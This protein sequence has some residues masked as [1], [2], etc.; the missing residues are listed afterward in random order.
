MYTWQVKVEGTPANISQEQ[1]NL[2]RI[3]SLQKGAMKVS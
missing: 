2:N 3:A 1:A